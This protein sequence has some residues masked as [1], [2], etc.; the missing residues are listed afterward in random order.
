[1][2]EILATVVTVVA[3]VAVAGVCLRLVLPYLLIGGVLLML[4]GA[5]GPWLQTL[6]APLLL[7]LLIAVAFRLML[8]RPI[9]PRRC[10]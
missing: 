8:G 2:D 7:M 10:E 4:S 3:V 9:V 6:A 1:M 5:C